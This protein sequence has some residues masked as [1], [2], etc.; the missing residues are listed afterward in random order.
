MDPRPKIVILEDD[1]VFA[2]L[3]A[4]TLEEYYEVAVGTNGRQGI[5]LC[6]QG[7]V[8]VIV[9]DLVMPDFDGVQMLKEFRKNPLLSS[10]PV[11]VVSAS[12]FSDELKKFPQVRRVFSKNE[13]A[14]TIYQAVR[15]LVQA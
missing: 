1:E 4:E 7:G 11:L 2:A 8:A 3:L 13:T 5:A 6:L 10:I 14:Q 12:D 9:T 15:Q